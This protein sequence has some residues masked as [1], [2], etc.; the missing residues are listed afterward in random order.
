L[1]LYAHNDVTYAFGTPE[2]AILIKPIFAQ[3]IQS[4][5]GQTSHGFDVLL[6]SARGPTFNASRSIRLLSWLNGINEN[7]NSLFLT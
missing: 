3:W 5:H 6:S 7:S 4:A 1:D 2:K